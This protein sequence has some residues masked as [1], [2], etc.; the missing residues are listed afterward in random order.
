VAVGAAALFERHRV[1][2]VVVAC[3]LAVLAVMNV[4]DPG[5]AYVPDAYQQTAVS[6]GRYIRERALPDQ[7]AYAL[8]ARV[9]VVY[10]SGLPSPFPYNWSLMMRSVPGAEERLRGLLASSDRPTWIVKAQSTRAFGLDR[11][12]ATK[13]L[14]ARYYRPAGTVCGTQLLLARG[15]GARPPPAGECRPAGSVASRADG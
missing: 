12:G 11:S 2:G 14:L 5:R 15:A 13:S 9:N 3:V 6:I 4:S 7:T 1:V 10:Y 8:Y